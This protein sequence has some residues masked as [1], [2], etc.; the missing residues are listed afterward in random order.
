MIQIEKNSELFHYFIFIE[1]ILT[2]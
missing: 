2:K 1:V